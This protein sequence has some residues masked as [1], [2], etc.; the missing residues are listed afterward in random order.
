MI[1]LKIFKGLALVTVALDAGLVLS[2]GSIHAD[3]TDAS[4]SSTFKSATSGSSSATGTTTANFSVTAGDGSTTTDGSGNTTTPNTGALQLTSAPSFNFGSINV[5]TIVNGRTAS[6]TSV[7]NSLSVKDYRGAATSTGSAPQWNVTAS[8]SKF[9]DAD[10]TNKNDLTATI[11]GLSDG[12]DPSTKLSGTTIGSSA[13]NVFSSSKNATNGIGT[14]SDTITSATLGFSGTNS[15]VS[16][17]SYSSTITWT[18]SNTA[19]S[20]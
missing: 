10:T 5:A 17:H 11:S 8:M 14:A 15:P 9:T 7:T 18:L 20:K 4:L 2:T 13:T 3:S 19:A 6:S 1:S 12:S 16:G